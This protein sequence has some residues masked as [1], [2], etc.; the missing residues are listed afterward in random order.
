MAFVL[1]G[2]EVPARDNTN[3]VKHKR[4]SVDVWMFESEAVV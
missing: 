3:A 1:P 2:V 4:L